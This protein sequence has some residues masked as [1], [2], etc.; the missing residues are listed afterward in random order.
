MTPYQEKKQKVLA[1]LTVLILFT[2]VGFLLFNISLNNRNKTQALKE[3]VQQLQIEKE[4]VRKID[5]IHLEIDNSTSTPQSTSTKSLLTSKAYLTMIATDGGKSK[6]L[7]EKNPEL[8]LPIA[9][10]TKLMSAVIVLENIDLKTE[11]KA[12]LDYVGKEESYFVLEVDKVY[13]AKEL[14]ANSLIPSD[15]DSVRLLSSIIGTNDFIT[16]MN[17]KAKELGL[18]NTKYVN[19]TGLDPKKPGDDMN[20]STVTD[21]SKLLLYI[22]NKHPE[23]LTITGNS[24]HDFCDIN[25]YCKEI[26][27]TNKLLNKPDLKYKIIG[28]KTGTTDLAGKNLAVVTE[29]MEGVS[30]INIVL[31][32]EDNFADSASLINRVIIGN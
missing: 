19:V 22:K 21:L 5:S 18:S 3:V 15:N 31:G 2:L 25:N 9:S 20:V 17:L 14:L 26:I 12:T 7:T 16:K 13:S 8:V 27:S 32:A 11:V 30:L 4:A 29:L 23:I 24:V 28:G 1:V 10:I 6:I